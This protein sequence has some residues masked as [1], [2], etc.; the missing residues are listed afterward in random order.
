MKKLLALAAL[1]LFIPLFHPKAEAAT[2]IKVSQESRA[3]AGDFNSNILGYIKAFSTAK[4]AVEYYKYSS[5][6]YGGLSNDASPELTAK[7]SHLFFVDAADGLSLFTVHDKP[8]NVIG[9][10]A[11]MRFDLLGDTASLKMVDD[12]GE[13]IASADGTVFIANHAWSP[14][15]TDGLAIGS[16]NGNWEMKVQFTGWYRGLNAWKAYSSSSKSSTISLA[17]QNYRRVQLNVVPASIPEPS[18]IA[19][20]VFASFLALS[21]LRRQRKGIL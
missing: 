20:I 6:Y 12:P 18:S 19:S 1:T 2:M 4:T 9:G 3:G 10:A 7:Q 11:K 5:H 8:G 21:V 13:A 14:C 17:M 15:C 16:L